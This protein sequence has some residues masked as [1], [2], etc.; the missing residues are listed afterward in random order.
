MKTWQGRSL[1][2]SVACGGRGERLIAASRALL[3]ASS[4][5]VTSFYRSE[6]AKYAGVV[7]VILLAYVLYATLIVLTVRRT[8]APRRRLDLFTQVVDLVACVTLMFLTEG[9][10]SP[11]FVY[12]VFSVLCA[13]L[14]W[15]VRG[16]VWTGVTAL[17]LYVGL[18]LYTAGLF[19]DPEFD[20]NRFVMRGA[21]LVVV[22]GLLA[23]FAAYERRLRHDIAA[24]AAWP[25]TLP[26]DPRRLIQELLGLTG[27]LLRCQRVAMVW[28]EPD[29][30]WLNV[31]S[32]SPLGFEWTRE[33][34]ATLEP[35]VN[36]SLDAWSFLW[37]DRRAVGVC[38]E[39]GQRAE[40]VPLDGPALHPGLGQR[41]H[42]P[43]ILALRLRGETITGR[44][45]C[46][47]DDA[48]TSDDLPFGDLV[49]Q[50][51]AAR[52]DRF[53][54]LGRL[55]EA[56]AASARTQMARDLHD[57]F[58]QVFTGVAL[59]LQL[60][61]RTVGDD[62]REAGARLAELERLITTE[63]ENLRAFV[64][65]LRVGPP[66]YSEGGLV[67]L[68]GRLERQWR[69]PVTLQLDDLRPWVL[70]ELADDVHHLLNEALANAARHGAAHSARVRIASTDDDVIIAV[71]DDGRGF[72][73]RGRYDAEELA[74]SGLGPVSLRE[75]VTALGGTL[76]VDSRPT[77]ARLEMRLPRLAGAF[78]R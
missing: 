72:S 65:D 10:A 14:R 58:L 22:A 73:F 30:P 23:Y 44:L 76:V 15:G 5:I 35:L 74:A 19:R 49:A 59:E 66:S 29:E 20:L 71:A 39:R 37:T 8:P 68:V 64:R 51:V 54:L 4:F 12:F 17:A 33:A 31:A 2:V 9:S 32:W 25:D 46:F 70:A 63:R 24:L 26:H 18:T 55:Q 38:V 13:A 45:L 42:A 43:T 60:L 27:T 77:G 67:S 28:G 53:H 62:P 52:L 75:R 50:H 40:V 11:F 16:A 7:N 78:A 36:E 41:F 1:T 56:A 6:P 61:Q 3:A 34:P 21:Y 69:L 47:D 48:R 57:T